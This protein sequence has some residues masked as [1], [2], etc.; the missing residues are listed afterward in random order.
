MKRAMMGLILIAAA[1]FSTGC[2]ATV[3]YNRGYYRQGYGSGYRYDHDW[4]RHNRRDWDRHD[5]RDRDFNRYDYH[6]Y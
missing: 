3:G 6:R 2:A 5:P 4:D 1:L